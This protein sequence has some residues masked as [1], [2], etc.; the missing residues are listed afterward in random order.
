[1]CRVPLRTALYGGAPDAGAP[2]RGLQLAIFV[3][4]TSGLVVTLVPPADGA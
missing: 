1:V 3:R 4:S 2:L